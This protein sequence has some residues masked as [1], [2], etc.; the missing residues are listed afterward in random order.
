MGA[1][2]GLGIAG[3][4]YA[5]IIEPEWLRLSTYTLRLSRLPPEFDGYRVAHLTDIHLDPWIRDEYLDKVALRVNQA[6]PDLVVVT[7]DFVRD[8]PRMYAARLERFLRQLSPPDGLLGAMGNH[9]YWREP[10]V[11]RASLRIGGLHVV[12]NSV[13]S[14]S[15]G[16]AQLWV[17]GVDSVRESHDRLDDVLRLLPPEGAALFLCHEPDF[18]VAAA[19]TQ[20]FDLQLSGHAH[21]GQVRLPGLGPMT[22]PRFGRRYP[23]GLYR[24]GGMWLYAGRGVGMGSPYLRF[25]CRPE[26][27]IFTLLSRP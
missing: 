26:I 4:V 8:H 6:A 15:R 5:H 16:Q 10:A 21:G 19:V 2:V 14:T 23:D 7:G 9:D 20:R 18:A 24:V 17:A 13:W 22:L 11:V 25:N 12:R 3:Y 1:V 27:A